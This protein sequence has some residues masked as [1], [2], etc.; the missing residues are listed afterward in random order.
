MLST[1]R[2]YMGKPKPSPTPN[3]HTTTSR[4]S[5]PNASTAFE[6]LAEDDSNLPEYRHDKDVCPVCKTDRFLN[7]RLRLLVSS[8]YH[9]MCESCIDRIFTLGP[10]PCP[11]CGVTIRK[12]HFRKQVYENLHVQREITIRTRMAKIY[13]KREDDFQDVNAYNA[14]LQ[15]VEDLTFDLLNEK[16]V[17]KV[18]Q[19]LGRYRAEN[20]ESIQL[21]LERG[22]AE[23][24]EIKKREMQQRMEKEEIKRGYER[25]DLEEREMKE[26]DRKKV[27]LALTSSE[28]DAEQVVRAVRSSALKRS[29]ARLDA[30]PILQSSLRSLNGLK[31]TDPILEDPSLDPH[32]VLSDL[33]NWDSYSDLYEIKGRHLVKGGY[34]EDLGLGREKRSNDVAGFVAEQVWEKCIRSAVAGLWLRPVME[35]RR[36]AEEEDDVEGMDE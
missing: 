35:E 8:C 9:R 30:G 4:T 12:A 24:E 25:M 17:E 36:A 23:R 14:Y 16:D 7:P 34:A 15:E 18:E 2:F 29:T 26:R 6:T 33:A 21:N 27:L 32:D 31:S 1:P 20:Q 11:V 10:E 19:L 22:Q 3:P 28:K 13:N 5:R